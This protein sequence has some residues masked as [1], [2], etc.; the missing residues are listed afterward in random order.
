MAQA[1][2]VVAVII[3]TTVEVSRK[4]ALIDAIES[5]RQ[6][7]SVKAIPLLIANGKRYDPELFTTLKQR[8]DLRFVY[9][10]EGSLP[11]AI[12]TG[13]KMV[14]TPFFAFL[15][16]D[17]RYLPN[18]L[19]LRLTPLL[20]D[21]S[22]DV[23]ITTGYLA[24]GHDS[25]R[26]HIEGIDQ[27]QVDPLAAI[28]QRNWLASCGGL[29]RSSGV[30]AEYFDDLPKYREWTAV[31][32]RLALHQK[33][34]RFLAT[35]TYQVN[36]STASLSKS[37]GYLLGGTQLIATMLTCKLPREVSRRLRKK[38]ANSL[39]EISDYYRQQGDLKKAWCYHLKC[40]TVAGGLKYWSYVRKLYPHVSLSSHSLF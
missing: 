8:R 4:H 29:Y 27:C 12:A 19:S 23:V 26:L 22:V 15:D 40:L 3:P 36:D 34:L 35:P 20:S 17:D 7:R 39:H 10:Q 9:I 28:A 31:A 14:D 25:R 2:T 1:E 11:Q 32:F 13:R 33:T 21:S 24:N 18:A 38:Y 30:G 37:E 5:V 16:D 6:Q